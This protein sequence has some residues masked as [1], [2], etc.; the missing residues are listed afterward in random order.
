MS[1][2][3]GLH[4]VIGFL[5]IL[6]LLQVSS[7]DAL[8]RH[9]CAHHDA[10][11]ENPTDGHHHHGEDTAPTDDSSGCTCV[12]TCSIT[13][14]VVTPAAGALEAHAAGLVE[15]VQITGVGGT[16]PPTPAYLLPYSTAP[17]SS[18]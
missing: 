10:I 13:G 2:S 17:P 3:R 7:G 5:A 18:F 6:L 14:P 9:R 15:L 16:A 1:V 4:R 12:G 11:P 8:T